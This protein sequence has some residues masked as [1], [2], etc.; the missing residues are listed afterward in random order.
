MPPEAM[1]KDRTHH[2]NNG[3]IDPD[4]MHEYNRPG[5][6]IPERALWLAVLHRAFVDAVDPKCTGGGD[7]PSTVQYYARL[8]FCSRAQ[9]EGS[10]RWIC[11]SLGLSP[12]QASS[13]LKQSRTATRVRSRYK[14]MFDGEGQRQ[15]AR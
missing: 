2:P 15:P 5:D 7:V 3:R 4:E 12:G 8:W 1:L 14:T 13:L 10:F 6:I 11:D 9:C